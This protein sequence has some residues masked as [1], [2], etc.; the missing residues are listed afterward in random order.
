MN[1]INFTLDGKGVATMIDTTESTY[2]A[3]FIRKLIN[4]LIANNIIL[5]G[6]ATEGSI[7]F[8]T[9]TFSVNMKA[10]RPI[11]GFDSWDEMFTLCNNI[12]Y[13]I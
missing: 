12:N 7:D 6:T 10:C 8:N 3:G 9:D 4:R 11:G 13:G 2:D 5:V 1:Y